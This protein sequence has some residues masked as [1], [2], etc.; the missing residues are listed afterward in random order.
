MSK[1]DK[2]TVLILV[3]WFLPGYKAGG[4]I[5]SVANMVAALCNEFH[6][7]VITGNTD[8]GAQAPYEEI[9]SDIWV[10]RKD[11]QVMYLS[12]A[13]RNRKHL[14]KLLTETNYDFIYLNSV[15]SLWY[16]LVP[17]VILKKIKNQK[18]IVLAPRGM[19]GE[20]ALRVKPLKKKVFLAA[21]KAMKLF[22]RVVWHASS[23]HEAGRIKQIFGASTKVKIAMNLAAVDAAQPKAL[24]KERGTARFFFLSRIVPIKN[25][26]QAIQM[27]V[28]LEQAQPME[29]HLIGPIEDPEYWAQCQQLA[30]KYPDRVELKYLGEVPHPQIASTLKN[31]HFLLMPTR[32]ENYGHSIVEALSQGCPVVISD[33]TPWRNLKE[34]QVGWDLD[35]A[36][37][38]TFLAALEQAID[39][40]A[41]EYARWSQNALTFVRENVNNEEILRAN[42][43]LFAG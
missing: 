1:S 26:L 37:E 39:M 36:D 10:D 9:S 6:F 35:L 25:I 42:R 29:Y 15:F 7:L 22:E 4:P 17:L 34:K 14:R 32:N 13:N 3:D 21:S 43:H 41:D 8:F 40:D 16:T 5:R 2:T 27:L 11:C 19:L 38:A 23:E 31:Y 18:P 33:Q 28:R 30:A 24:P 20:G 12:A